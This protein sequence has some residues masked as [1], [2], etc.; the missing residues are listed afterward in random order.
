MWEQ[1]VDCEADTMFG[2]LSSFVWM[3]FGRTFL[4]MRE[5][6]CFVISCMVRSDILRKLDGLQR[7]VV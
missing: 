5:V 3:Q 2:I 6:V 1:E 7:T 4:V